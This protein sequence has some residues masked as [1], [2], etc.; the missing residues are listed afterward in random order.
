MLKLQKDEH[1]RNKLKT[2]IFKVAIVC[3]TLLD[4]LKGD[5]ITETTEKL[6]EFQE[7]PFEIIGQYIKEYCDKMNLI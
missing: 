1:D 6:L 3:V 5:Q 4:R 7:R 2:L